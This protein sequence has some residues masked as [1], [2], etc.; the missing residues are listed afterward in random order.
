MNPKAPIR[1]FDVFAEYTR[2]KALQ[3]GMT[4]PRPRAT[5]CGS[6]K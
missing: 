6:P 3:D 1:R 4:K 5:A 2:Q